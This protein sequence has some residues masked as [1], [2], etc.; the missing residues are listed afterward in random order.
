[1]PHQC[2]LACS[3]KVLEVR[4]CVEFELV[5]NYGR[6]AQIVKIVRIVRTVTKKKRKEK[7]EL[8]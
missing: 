5:V 3:K 6:K 8:N 7:N 4:Q 2:V 1:M